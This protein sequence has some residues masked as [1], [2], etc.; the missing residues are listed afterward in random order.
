M[1]R[2]SWKPRRRITSASRIR[3]YMCST[4]G[5][6]L[7]SPLVN[8][9]S[10][11][12]PFEG[13]RRGVPKYVKLILILSVLSLFRENKIVN[14]F[15]SPASLPPTVPPPPKEIYYLHAPKTGTTIFKEMIQYLCPTNTSQQ[16]DAILKLIEQNK[17]V[18]AYPCAKTLRAGHAGLRPSQPIHQTI[19]FLRHPP[20]RLA[21]GFLHNL[22]DCPSLQKEIDISSEHE[23]VEKSMRG[24]CADIHTA[25]LYRPRERNS[26]NATMY[27]RVQS[28]VIS[29]LKCVRGCATNMLLG[30]S[31]AHAE[32]TEHQKQNHT[33]GLK[34]HST[35]LSKLESLAFVG[36]TERWDESVCMFQDLFYPRLYMGPYLSHGDFEKYKLRAT[37]LIQCKKDIESM[38]RADP[39]IQRS[40][41]ED[42]DWI[43]YNRSLELFEDRL[44]THCKEQ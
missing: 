20:G 27:R 22:H 35:I 1:N 21:S 29:Y 30:H 26:L 8:G 24:I 43:L 33:S 11:F 44:P 3:I 41:E 31:C 32:V 25:A 36:I 13:M 38:F 19:T 15:Q 18:Q 16:V 5:L 42:P 39:L 34:L 23:A 2:K 37:P 12:D 17:H 7:I 10:T 14:V 9:F 6:R 40:I 4:A 28:M